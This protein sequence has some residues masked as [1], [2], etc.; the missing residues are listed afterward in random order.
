[1]SGPPTLLLV[2]KAPIA[3]RAKTMLAA[4]IGDAAA[5]QVAAA[6]L[7][8]TLDVVVGL[9]WPVVVAMTGDLAEAVRAQE[10]IAVCARHRVI[11]QRG[12]SFAARL[13]AAHGDADAG[14]GVVQIGMDTPQLSTGDLEIAASALD[15]HDAALGLADDGGWWV[16]AVRDPGWAAYL[17][18]VRTSS[19]DTGLRT[20]AA[21]ESAGASVAAL[22]PLSDVDTWTDACFV[23][24]LIPH[25]R[26]ATEVA[27]SAEANGLYYRA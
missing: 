25:S 18:T 27:R 15:T 26:F 12:D 11:P 21:L 7:L 20:R 8:D 1:M 17:A 5:A 9:G 13:V 3:G 23:A 4:T 24:A 14:H 19:P 22:P 2:A 6:A 16:L 10:I